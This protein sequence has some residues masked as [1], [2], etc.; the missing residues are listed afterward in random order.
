VTFT[1]PLINHARQICFLVNAKKD[2]ELIE[3]VL[4]GDRRYPASR[5]N[6][7]AGELTWIIGQ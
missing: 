1:F 7:T 4:A 3:R 5:V 2:E 6:P